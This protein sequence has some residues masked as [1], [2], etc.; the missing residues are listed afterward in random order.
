MQIKL[1]KIPVR[2]VVNGYVDSAENGVVGYGSRL[3]I[4]PAFQ[5][6]FIYKDR[7]RDEVIH[8]VMRNFPLNVMYWVKGDNG[9]FEVLDG[10][11]R[12]ISICQ[13]VTDEFSIVMDDMPRKFG[14]LTQTEQ[15]QI[16]EPNINA[17]LI[18]RTAAP[19]H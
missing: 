19:S 9:N 4:R 16:L 13:Y 7:Q 8:T 10:Q 12:T 17:F 1:H 3:N 11:Q 14:N 18:T 15:K 2:D 5:R 6:E